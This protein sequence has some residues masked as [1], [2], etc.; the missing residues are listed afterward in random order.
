MYSVLF[1]DTPKV[2]VSLKS[3]PAEPAQP[4]T[5]HTFWFGFAA[6]VLYGVLLQLPMPFSTL[7]LIYFNILLF[8]LL[9]NI[10]DYHS[11]HK[12]SSQMRGA[13]RQVEHVCYI[14]SVPLEE[15][16]ETWSMLHFRTVTKQ[17]YWQHLWI[18]YIS[19]S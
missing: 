14:V 8:Y 12:W 11:F 17:Y 16:A 7:D 2:V 6:E 9:E 15:K 13:R 18:W 10:S 5:V 1:T 4:F 19:S 3:Q